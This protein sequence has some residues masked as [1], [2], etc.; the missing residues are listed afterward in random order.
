MRAPWIVAAALA[1]LAAAGCSRQEARWQEAARADSV[2]AYEEYLA[3]F[4]AGAHAAEAKARI[5]ELREGRDWSKAERLRTPEAWQAYLAEWPA[6]RHA[7]AAREQLARYVPA[8][9]P[10]AGWSVQLGAFSTERAAQSAG[11]RLS[12]SQAGALAA[13]PLR[14]LAPQDDPGGVWRLRTGPMAEADARALCAQLKERG[15]DCLPVAE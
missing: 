7:D 14:I 11:A 8:A 5:L 10:D 1:A 15:A 2:A 13:Q 9:A 6:G 4:P 12:E 3:G